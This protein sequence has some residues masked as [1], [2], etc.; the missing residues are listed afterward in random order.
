MSTLSHSLYRRYFQSIAVLLLF[1]AAP[2]L[3]A[4]PVG[5]PVQDDFSSLDGWAEY[6]GCFRDTETPDLS[7][8]TTQS[9]DMTT[10]M[11]LNICRERGNTYAATQYSSYCHCGNSYGVYGPADNCQMICSGNSQQTCGGSWANS[12]YRIKT[13]TVTTQAK[14]A[15][16]LEELARRNE[17]SVRALIAFNRVSIGD[18]APLNELRAQ[19]IDVLSASPD[20]LA[21]MLDDKALNT[22]QQAA[23]EK[24]LNVIKTVESEAAGNDADIGSARLTPREPRQL[25]PPLPPFSLP[26]AL[27]MVELGSAQYTGMISTAKEA[28]LA[29]MGPLSE[30]EAARVEQRWAGYYAHPADDIVQYFRHATPILSELL[31]IREAIALTSS[32]FD[33]AWAEATLAAQY[34]SEA[35]AEAEL[36]QAVL[37]KDYLVALEA[38]A[39]S[40]AQAMQALGD[41]PDPIA[42]Q[43]AAAGK[44]RKSTDTLLGLLAPATGPEGI[45]YGVEAYEE[46]RFIKGITEFPTLFVVYSVGPASEQRYRALMLDA[47]SYDE[48]TDPYIDV[49]EMHEDEGT[50]LPSLYPYLKNGRIQHSF[51][52][53]E[54]DEDGETSTW[55]T[56][57]KAQMLGD[58]GVA[59]YPDSVSVARAES[60]LH[61]MLAASAKKEE[62]AKTYRSSALDAFNNSAEY[63]P[64]DEN[65]RAQEAREAR[66]AARAAA[67]RF[68]GAIQGAIETN[69]AELAAAM[70]DPIIE[71]FARSELDD[72][73]RHH[74]LTPAFVAAAH[75]WLKQ[76]P[77]S[78]HTDLA[79][80]RARLSAMIAAI[81]GPSPVIAQAAEPVAEPATGSKKEDDALKEAEKEAQR[82]RIE[83]HRHNIRFVEANLARDRAELA[84]ETDPERRAALEFRIIGE[85]SDIQAEKDLIA[86][87][88]TGELV[89]TRSPFDDYAHANFL[90]NIRE[91]QQ[92]MERFQRNTASLLRLAAML[93]GEEGDNARAFVERQL[94]P[95]VRTKMDEAAI[96]QIADALGN[97]VQGYYLGQQAKDEEAAALANFGLESA[98]NIKTAADNSMMVASLFGGTAIDSTY[99]AVTGY[100]EGGPT[101]A[102][103]RTISNIGPRTSAAVEA[104]RGYREGG[105]TEAATRGS[106]SFLTSKSIEY[107][108]GKVIARSGRA[109]IDADAGRPAAKV[110]A[111][112]APVRKPSSGDAGYSLNGPSAFERE[113][114]AQ[115]NRARQEGEALVQDLRAAKQ[116]LADAGSAG[117]SVTELA[118]IQKDIHNKVIAING[119]PNAKNYLKYKGD[120][121]TQRM[122]VLELESIHERVERSFHHNM[123]QR[124]WHQQPLKEMRN[125]AS[126]G[127]VGMDYDIGLDETRMRELI[128]NGEPGTLYAWQTEAQTAWEEA[129]AMI[130][131][132]NAKFAWENVTTSKHAESY[133]DLAWLGTDKSK[134]SKAWGQQ[135]ADVTRYKSWHMLHEAPNLSYFE[136]LQEISRGAAKDFDTKVSP[137]LDRIKPSTASADNFKNSRQHWQSIRQVMAD[138]GNNTIDPITANRRIR[139]LT[140]GKDIPQVVDEMAMLMEAAVKFGPGS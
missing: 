34:E 135:A 10:E 17:L 102:V 131:G 55:I 58:D 28:T 49:L 110:T 69:A 78:E 9:S 123:R 76:R 19:G 106:I 80:D 53:T 3:M 51:E 57:L 133:R 103:L 40:L 15:A 43:S 84:A 77:F 71:A 120:P 38:R 62:P 67:A 138:F 96:K 26:P 45:W 42:A 37:L 100:I 79:E 129:Y 128:H 25:P 12:V 46:E 1:L 137:M 73:R 11:C 35:Y 48:K 52:I 91:S 44:H 118:Q 115:F 82:E 29:L 68:G 140:G 16:T 74:E 112:S 65:Q 60:A 36:T 95:E 81:A 117:R 88:E 8:H 101:E 83:F 27:P 122:F 130:T 47:G 23:L 61:T 132:D 50:P 124:G 54:V 97:R 113:A 66:E 7:A 32:A 98:Q 107:G 136:R 64:P 56:T 90:T 21:R 125:A 18:L 39:Q 134:V 109:R 99:Q 92:R 126:A 70:R 59:N 89:R 22:S 75:K 24:I 6:I 2:G 104:I 4:N 119:N 105:L 14:T 116:R 13:E 108:M 20:A 127:S 93:P 30:E 72:L 33:D 121:T 85:L 111:D 87:I 94:T 139:M 31:N 5:N 41:A 63:T 86:S 114:Q